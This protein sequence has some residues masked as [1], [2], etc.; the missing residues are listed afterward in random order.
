MKKLFLLLI[1]LVVWSVIIL[2]TAW[3]FGA[4]WFDLPYPELRHT[5]AW[6]YLVAVLLMLLFLRPR[7][8]ARF[9]AFAAPIAIA[10]WWLTLAP[11]SHP[12]W[13][14]D[15]A[16]EPWAEIHGDLVTIHNVRN[17]YYHS[18]VDYIPCWETRTI[19][20]SQI[21][22]VD[23]AINYWGSH[24]IA[25]PIVSFQFLE[26]PPLAVSIETRRQKG[27][28]YSPIAGL[29]RQYGLVY[30]AAD[31]R[32]VIRLRTNYRKG[33]EIYLYRTTLSPT[34]ARQL[35]LEYVRTMND[36]HTKTRWYNAITA[37]C[38]TAI[39]AQRAENHRLP[40]DWR[41]LLNGSMDAM[42]YEYGL[43]ESHGLSYEELKKRALINSA[44]QE[45]D[46]SRDF[47]ERIRL[48]RP[49]F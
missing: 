7:G 40:W 33:E 29:Y 49:G 10:A 23:V 34:E 9:C 45:A 22:G 43:L 13:Q 25:H 14:T 11:N 5:I 3:G 4:I 39:R 28:D 15:V 21:T 41:I 17:F 36:L 32:D 46:T 42:L 12:N 47:S 19:H 30:I 2:G 31:E 44:A 1:G 16:L 8:L 24:W 20:L 38:T 27:Q 18:A 26:A 6:D 35:F 37:N 48:G